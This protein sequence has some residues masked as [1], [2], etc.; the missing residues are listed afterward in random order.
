LPRAARRD[1]RDIVGPSWDRRDIDTDD[2]NPLWAFALD[3]YARPGVKEAC[4]RLQ[5]EHGFDVDMVL[6]ALWLAT[7][8]GAIDGPHWGRLVEAAAPVRDWIVRVRDLRHEAATRAEAEPGW[9]PIAEAALA[10]ELRAER[11]QLSWLYGRLAGQ[12]LPPASVRDAAWASLRAYAEIL[13]ISPPAGDIEILV[14]ALE[15]KPT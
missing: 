5:R 15:T 8:G 6:A 2:D 10:A 3:V 9:R 7:R 11:R 14:A 12:S 1:P 13:G 4:L